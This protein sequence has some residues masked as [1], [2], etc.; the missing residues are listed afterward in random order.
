MKWTKGAM[1]IWPVHFL[2]E[3][4]D[5]G[6]MCVFL[7][8]GQISRVL[9][10]VPTSSTFIKLHSLMSKIEQKCNNN[11]TIKNGTRTFVQYK[12][13]TYPFMDKIENIFVNGS[14]YYTVYFWHDKI[15]ILVHLYCIVIF[16]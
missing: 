1:S 15:Y 14:S 4:N 10:C 5:S 11:K 7:V 2:Y 8:R 9:H 3:Y 12:S 13:A 6:K 16:K